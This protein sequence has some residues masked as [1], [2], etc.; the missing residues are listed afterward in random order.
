MG[1]SGVGNGG[2]GPGKPLRIVPGIGFLCSR[3]GG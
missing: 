3:N 2:E 1:G